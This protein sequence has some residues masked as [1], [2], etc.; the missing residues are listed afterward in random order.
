[1]GD[2]HSQVLW[3]A[4]DRF[5]G[6][7]VRQDG[8][9]LNY[10]GCPIHPGSYD[11]APNEVA[12]RLSLSITTA[13]SY[14][15]K[16]VAGGFL[17]LTVLIACA[18]IDSAVATQVEGRHPKSRYFGLHIHRLS[19]AQPWVQY[20][21]RLTPWPTVQFGSLRLWDAYVGWPSIQPEPRKW[22][23][24][25]LDHYVNIAQQHDVEVV[26]PLG[27]TPR[28]ASARPAEPSAYQQGNAAEPLQIDWWRAYVRAVVTRYKGRI[29]AYEIWNEANTKEFF[30]GSV[31][32][33]VEL[34]C[35]AFKEIK[36]VDADAVVLSP[37]GTGF[38]PH[39]DWLERYLRLGGSE[40]ADA[41]SYHFYVPWGTPEEM[42]S[43]IA[44]VR[45]V[46]HRTGNGSKQLWNTE[47]GW[48]LENGD[49]TPDHEMVTRR[50]WKRLG[51]KEESGAY[52]ARALI[53]GRSAGL[54]RFFWYSW[55]NLYGLGM[56]EPSS[57]EPKPIAAAVEQVGAWLGRDENVLCSVSGAVW[58]CRI[59]SELQGRAWIVWATKD[60]PLTW[61]IPAIWG[62][63]AVQNLSGECL[64]VDRSRSL[65]LTGSPVALFQ[66]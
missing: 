42:L 19:Q 10:R 66:K 7:S 1:M 21:A 47:T 29:A 9:K 57:G 4:L 65:I 20:G 44:S 6:L 59:G 60:R 52:L 17:V 39:I 38:G 26:L 56:L 40:C 55:D 49:G 24:S 31:E 15:P 12:L 3:K 25:G 23:F 36:A 37:S 45:K 22:N 61:Q 53:L 14:Y 8:L 30:T 33:L 63:V 43:I 48:W 34:S 62:T 32:Q 51:W 64:P 13:R 11:A 5:L 54:S 27:L 35:T 50:R 2:L 46:M 58:S 16:R 28:W 18:A 41:I